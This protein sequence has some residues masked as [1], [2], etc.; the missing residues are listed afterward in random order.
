MNKEG[1]LLRISAL[2]AVAV[3]MAA[4][5]LAVSMTSVDST[6][7]SISYTYV[8]LAAGE[9]TVTGSSY[10][11]YIWVKSDESYETEV[12]KGTMKS[13]TYFYVF[14]SEMNGSIPTGYKEGDTVHL[15]SNDRVVGEDGK[16]KDSDVS[17]IG[18]TGTDHLES[19]NNAWDVAADSVGRNSTSNH[20]QIGGSERL[21]NLNNDVVVVVD[22]I[23][24]S[25][26]SDPDPNSD[27]HFRLTGG[28]AV[29]TCGTST[30]VTIFLKGDN[31]VGNLFYSSI[32]EGDNRLILDVYGGSDRNGT[33]VAGSPND[34]VLNTFNSVIGASDSPED[35][36]D[37]NGMVI[38][39]GTIYVGNHKNEPCTGIGGGGNG[40][41]GLTISGGIITAMAHTGGS[42]IGGGG[43]ITSTGGNAVITITGGEIYAYNYG[44]KD[45]TGKIRLGVAIGSG[46]SY[47]NSGSAAT[48]TITGGTIHAE[49]YGSTA[50]GSGGTSNK[51]KTSG[52]ASITISGS[53]VIVAEAKSGIVEGSGSMVGVAIGT[54][55]TA[56]KSG[57]ATINISGG[58][59]TATADTGGYG[60][61]GAGVGV[62]GQAPADI[63]ITGGTVTGSTTAPPKGERGE[64]LVSRVLYVGGKDGQEV[65]VSYKIGGDPRNTTVKVVD[66][67]ISIWIPNGSENLEVSGG[68][69]LGVHFYA[70]YYDGQP[71]DAVDVS[72]FQEK[73]IKYYTK[74]PNGNYSECKLPSIT[75]AGSLNVKVEITINDGKIS[76]EGVASVMKR[77]VTIGFNRVIIDTTGSYQYKLVTADLSNLPD[78]FKVSASDEYAV[79]GQSKDISSAISTNWTEGKI[80]ILDGSDNDR[81][82]NFTVVFD[83]CIITLA[84]EV[85]ISFSKDGGD[86]ISG[87]APS[88]KWQYGGGSITLPLLGNGSSVFAGWSLESG[89][90]RI[91]V[92]SGYILDVGGFVRNSGS[93]TISIKPVWIDPGYSGSLIIR[94]S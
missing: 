14:Q 32:G 21:G 49:S 36:D 86:V 48:I 69:A 34:S 46:S 15:P 9:F 40:F 85:T 61:G 76:Y 72:E 51:D 5:L 23:W 19:V 30:S 82:T 7:G 29:N 87:S 1:R 91:H 8:D 39:G 35:R 65:T 16:I 64:E 18:S 37:V 93:T 88:D 58:T 13:L 77:E 22:S 28:I 70:D 2:L 6:D 78:G 41:C 66:G 94:S 53:A 57:S 68:S 44:I 43:G 45:D 20:I 42:A 67:F 47:G 75:E 73:D 25:H 12:V 90:M 62:T 52:D 55:P 24:S 3:F 10:Q 79:S 17:I 26:Q 31:R 74:D 38:K 60:I 27:P 59:V 80:K 50:I 4:S 11:G 54:T 89:T 92:A 33:L 81:T 63:K 84:S 71:H 83:E 56:G